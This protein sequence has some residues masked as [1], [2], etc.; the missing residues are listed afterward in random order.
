MPNIRKKRLELNLTQEEL[1]KELG[2]SRQS[3]HALEKGISEPSFEL[4]RKLENFFKTSWHK[5]FPEFCNNNTLYFQTKKEEPMREFFEDFK[6]YF[7]PFSDWDLE[8]RFRKFS[9]WPRVNLRDEGDVFVLEAD[10]PGFSKE[11]VALEVRERSI[12]IRG[13]RRKEEEVKKKS[14][15]YHEA[16]A[17]KIERVISLPEPINTEEVKAELKDG[18]LKAIL[19]KLDSKGQG[20]VIKPE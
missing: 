18:R 15:F 17:S 8:T 10:L 12:T 1:A 14:Y 6:T 7:T 19:P 11:D 3:L 16:C 9:N 2:I 4:V 20:R 13:E 5:L